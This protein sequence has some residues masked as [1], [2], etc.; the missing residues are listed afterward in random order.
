MPRVTSS[1]G[2]WQRCRSLAVLHTHGGAQGTG[3]ELAERVDHLGRLAP[4]KNEGRGHAD[5]DDPHCDLLYGAHFPIQSKNDSV[6]DGT[7]GSIRAKSTAIRAMYESATA[8]SSQPLSAREKAPAAIAVMTGTRQSIGFPFTIVLFTTVIAPTARMGPVLRAIGSASVNAA[9]RDTAVD[10]LNAGRYTGSR[11]VDHVC[12]GH[13]Y[14]DMPA[15]AAEIAGGGLVARD[16]G[17]ALPHQV[18]GGGRSRRREVPHAVVD[19]A[20]RHEPGAV[21]PGRGVATPAVRN[22][23]VL[24]GV[25]GDLEPQR[26]TTSGGS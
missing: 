17:R 7:E 4:G 14:S 19:Q 22:A 5:A 21:P 20:P 1:L 11:C 15:P 6:G 13:R 25:H 16:R 12:V 23:L 10:L 2:R 24:L 18:L 8:P 3:E 9:N 26:G